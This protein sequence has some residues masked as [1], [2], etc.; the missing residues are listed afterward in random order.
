M[1]QCFGP[2]LSG[3]GAC[4]DKQTSSGLGC[5]SEPLFPAARLSRADGLHI[6]ER[7]YVMSP[8]LLH[9]RVSTSTMSGLQ[10]FGGFGVFTALSFGQSHLAAHA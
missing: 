5:F 1:V 4:K 8:R 3:L 2:K 7:V 10:G 9:P 6:L